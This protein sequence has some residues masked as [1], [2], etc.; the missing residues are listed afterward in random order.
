MSVYGIVFLGLVMHIGET[1]DGP[2]THAAMP[3]VDD[4]E[5]YISFGRGD[6]VRLVGVREIV[7]GGPPPAPAE[8]E[9]SFRDLVPRV[10]SIMGGT[11]ESGARQL[12]SDDATFVR[13]VGGTLL[14][15]LRYP[16]RARHIRRGLDGTNVVRNDFVGGLTAVVFESDGPVTISAGAALPPRTLTPDSLIGIGNYDRTNHGDPHDPV[17]TD[18]HF[19][20]Y[21]RLTNLSNTDITIE[22]H[23][24]VSRPTADLNLGIQIP[25][26]FPAE[27]LLN[28]GILTLVH[29]ECGNSAWP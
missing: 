14:A 26:W 21:A 25:S 19:K 9:T 11:L 28:L 1:E 20:R 2:K 22:E 13:Y 23:G 8:Q 15:G 18:P 3:W 6:S 7:I 17:R 16:R 10:K 4:H 12:T 27:I 24:S 29:S 5:I